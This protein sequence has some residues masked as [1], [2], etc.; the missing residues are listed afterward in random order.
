MR[1]KFVISVLFCIVSPKKL[2]L[3]LSISIFLMAL[4]VSCTL[5]IPAGYIIS[6]V[7]LHKGKEDIPEERNLTAQKDVISRAKAG[8]ELISSWLSVTLEEDAAFKLKK[9]SEIRSPGKEKNS[10]LYLQLFFRDCAP[11]KSFRF[12]K[13]N[14]DDDLFK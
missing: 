6:S 2:K 14:E 11:P 13:E 10:S 7:R 4:H 3:D 8:R 9:D 5:Q 1:A 12:E